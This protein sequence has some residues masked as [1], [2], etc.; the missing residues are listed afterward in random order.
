MVATSTEFLQCDCL[1][2]KAMCSCCVF[3][4]LLLLW[5][6][7]DAAA[8]ARRFDSMHCKLA[9]H[10]FECGYWTLCVHKQFLFKSFSCRSAN[11]VH[12]PFNHSNAK[13]NLPEL[14]SARAER[15][16]LTTIFT[17]Q[18]LNSYDAQ[19]DR[20]V[21]KIRKAFQIRGMINTVNVLRFVAS[22]LVFFFL[23]RLAVVVVIDSIDRFLFA[24]GLCF[25]RLSRR[26]QQIH[27]AYRIS[28]CVFQTKSLLVV[29]YA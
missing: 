22:L 20:Y 4:L 25:V 12:T 29:V 17:S 23:F 28:L 27:M 24:F 5:L 1:I 6:N 10:Q 7:V 16:C 2:M 14:V 21:N 8:L 3:V 9:V 11:C 18:L 13:P 15:S 19:R 26:N